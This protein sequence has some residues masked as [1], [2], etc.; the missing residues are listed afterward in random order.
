MEKAK[1]RDLGVT[2]H[3]DEIPKSNFFLFI[4]KSTKVAVVL[5]CA[6]IFMTPSLSNLIDKYPKVIILECT[7]MAL[8]LVTILL[9]LVLVFLLWKNGL[10]KRIKK[11]PERCS[12]IICSCC[13]DRKKHP[14]WFQLKYL[15]LLLALFAFNQFSLTKIQRFFEADQTVDIVRLSQL[16]EYQLGFVVSLVLFYFFYRKLTLH[17]GSVEVEFNVNEAETVSGIAETLSV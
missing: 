9:L 10:L 16:F 6:I 4:E 1:D 7:N 5:C 15:L 12:K 3:Q 14:T 17:S 11:N 13:A 8:Q 2:I